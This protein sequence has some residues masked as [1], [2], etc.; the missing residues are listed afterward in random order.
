MGQY[1]I[2]LPVPKCL[3]FQNFLGEHA[4]VSPSCPWANALAP[5]SALAHPQYIAAALIRE[6]IYY[7]QKQHINK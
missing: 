4:P 7:Q 5:F 3:N 2:P 6:Q 1:S